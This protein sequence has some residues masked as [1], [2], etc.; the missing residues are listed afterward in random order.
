[1]IPSVLKSATLKEDDTWRKNCRLR[2]HYACIAK[3]VEMINKFGSEDKY[4]LCADGQVH[5]CTYQYIPLHISTSQYI[6]VHTSTYLYILERTITYQVHLSIYLYVRVS[7]GY[8]YTCTYG[9]LLH[10][11]TKGR[12]ASM[13]SS[14]YTYESVHTRTYEYIHIH[15]CTYQ[16]YWYALVCTCMYHY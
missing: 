2:L 4:L 12:T 3:V 11:L 13:V 5:T 7:Y 10:M 6:P 15:I 9:Y 1:M 14:M 8:L 16:L